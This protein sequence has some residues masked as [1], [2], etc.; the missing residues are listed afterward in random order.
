MGDCEATTSLLGND[1]PPAVEIVNAN[2]R[3][4]AVLVCDHASNRVPQSLNNLGLDE[5]QL[6]DHIAWDPGAADVARRL[7]IHLDATLVLSG[8]SRLVIDCNRPLHSSESVAEQSAGVIVPGNAGLSRA[9]N[10]LRIDAL[11]RPYH[12]TIAGLLDG[13]G[14]RPSFL[15]S[16]HSF[17]PSLNGRS[18]PWHIGI[19][20]GRDRRLAAL[21]LTALR[22]NS[23]IVVGDN[24]PYPIEDGFDYTLPTHGD[25]RGLP[26]AMIEIRQ[27]CIRTAE[28]AA[29]W[30]A[31]MATAYRLIES[32]ALAIFAS[33]RRT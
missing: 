13:R 21:I 5:F 7:S 15:L 19:S 33:A 14:Q 12:D 26:Y 31:Q 22:R 27:D 24:E 25:A 18:R 30:A 1:E 20:H 6:A 9:C 8:Y 17:T 16:I 3:S 32:E 4:S 10:A 11:F 2:G 29:A 28:D 23:E